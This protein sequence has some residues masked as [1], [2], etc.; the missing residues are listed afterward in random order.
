MRENDLTKLTEV[1]DG[2]VASNKTL[3][4]NSDKNINGINEQTNTGK[5]K[6]DVVKNEDEG[7]VDLV[8]ARARGNT[9]NKT[10][11]YHRNH[12]GVISLMLMLME[13]T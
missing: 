3:V 8:F 10:E 2:Q 9:I 13:I 4:V 12:I 6:F 1:S 11:T 5:M 7:A